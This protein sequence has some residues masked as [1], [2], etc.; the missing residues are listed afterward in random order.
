MWMGLSMGTSWLLVVGE[1]GILSQRLGGSFDHQRPLPPHRSR[2]SG[3]GYS[4]PS[5]KPPTLF[6]PARQSLRH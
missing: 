3:S 6:F 2:C 5:C 1:A 4:L